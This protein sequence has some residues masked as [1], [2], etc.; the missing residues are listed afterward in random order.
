V[1]YL[2]FD[3]GSSQLKAAILS[4]DGRL[5]S[6][7]REPVSLRHG[8]GGQHESDPLNWVEAALSAG[9][10][11]VAEAKRTASRLEVRAVAVSGN[12]PTLLAADASGKPIG[13]ALSWL[14]RRAIMEASEVSALAGKP[15]D[16]SFYLPKALW[17]WRSADEGTR[18]RIRRFF[19][20]PE[21]L[22]YALCGEALTCLPAPGYEPYIWN[23]A[24]VAALGLPADRFPPFAAPAT[25]AG[26]LL[27]RVAEGLGLPE[28]APVIV[29]FPDFLAAIVGSGSIAAGIACDRTGTSEALNLCADRPFPTRELLSLPHPI[30]GLWN[31]SGGVS[32]AGAALEWLVRTLGYASGEGSRQSAPG[33]AALHAEAEL[34]SPGASGLAFLPYLSGERA[35]LWDASRRAAFV[36]LSELHGRPDLARA[37]CESLAYGLRLSADLARGQDIPIRLVRVSGRAADDDFMCSLKADILDLPLEAPE[38][39][40]CEL[41]GDAIACATALGESSCMAEA[42][43]AFMKIRRRFEPGDSAPYAAGYAHFKAALEALEPVDGSEAGLR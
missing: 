18:S 29:G 16:P 2:C 1:A 25:I 19:A 41:T 32:T 14:D 6:S 40:D 26:R 8:P 23:E 27:P 24:M 21:Y 7:A 33:I 20:C 10:H 22:L 36:G 17:I 4:E 15:I 42:S 43:G 30:A 12:G 38:I 13:P 9:S 35:P 11:A 28:G 3:I 37:A 31:L 39:S 5:V 34:S